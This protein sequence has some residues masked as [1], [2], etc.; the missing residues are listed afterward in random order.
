MP[1]STKPL[2]PDD[3]AVHRERPCHPELVEGQTYFNR[4]LL[5]A[6]HWEWNVVTYLFLGGIMGGLGLIQLLADENDPAERRLRRATRI[7]S[8]ALAA[9][10]PAILITHLGRPERFLNMTRIVKF[11]SPM[12]LGV[13]GLILYSGAAGANVMRELAEGGQRPRWLRHLAPSFLPPLQALLGAF[14]A[15]YTGV[16]LSATAN[17]LWASG[18]R[19]IPAFSVCSGLSSGCAF[20]A[21]LATIDGN[22]E[23][24][25]KLERLE[26]VAS[27]AELLLLLDFRRR[28]GYYAKQMF[29]GKRGEKLRT[30]TMLAG[31][32]APTLLNIAGSLI[33]LPK[34]M[35]AIRTAAASIL[36]L[37]GGYVLR[38]TLIESGKASA[39][40]PHAAMRQPK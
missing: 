2:H 21:L 22:D 6:P 26:M 12:S 19:H 36:T 38:E 39:N 4:P 27:G 23:V 8:F 18:K 29:E 40:D 11:K 1:D 20:A 31:I 33:K 28:A 16:L 35:N 32:A 9:A 3:A 17:P 37:I 10:N 13:W 15:G 5:K 24:V 25:E 14:T 34:P 7:T 30:Y